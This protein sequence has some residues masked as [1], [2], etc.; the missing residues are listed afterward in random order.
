MN[1]MQL[2]LLQV[3]MILFITFAVRFLIRVRVLHWY[4]TVNEAWGD[5]SCASMNVEGFFL[6]TCLLIVVIVVVF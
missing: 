3:V 1:D 2:Q 4:A 6:A 5:E